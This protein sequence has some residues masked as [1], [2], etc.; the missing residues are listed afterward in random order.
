MILRKPYA[1][2][3]K[4][5]RFIHVI[6]SLLVIYSTYKTKI[7]LDFFNEYSNEIIN[8]TG[9]DL[10]TPLMPLFFQIIPLII[11]VVNLLLLFIMFIKKKPYLF[12][13]ISIGIFLFTFIILQISKST[14]NELYFSLIDIRTIRL[15]RD[16]ITLSFFTQLLSL[17]F[18]LIR[19]TGFD[20][21][22]FDFK[23]DMKQIEINEEDREEVEI[24]IKF[25]TNKK[26][27]NIRK[28]IRNFKY[29][30]KENKTLFIISCTLV[31][32]IFLSTITFKLVSVG[33]ILSQNDYFVGNNFTISVV[34]SYL[35]NDDYQ[36]KILSDEY[37]YLIIKLNIK[38]NTNKNIGLD[39]ATTKILIDNYLYTPITENRDS[40]FDF[41]FMYQGENIESDFQLKTLIYQ[42]PKQLADEKIIFYYVDKNNIDNDSNFKNTKVEIKYQNLIND[43]EE[44]EIK[45]SQQLIFE[46]SII[47]DYKISISG[48]DIKDEYKLNYNFCVTNE[49]YPS[50]EYITPT[51]ETNYDKSILKIKGTLENENKLSGIYDLYDFIE[52]FGSIKYTINDEVKYHSIK[53]KELKSKK[54]VENDIYYIEVL[55]E[56]E[57]ADNISLIFTIRNKK[58]EYILK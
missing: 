49:C 48:F 5:F 6:L 51:V 40:F 12:Y 4:H 34:D 46:N 24:Q 28:I 47:S 36:G 39:T 31:G 22:K 17:L 11:L 35:V 19:S 14:L 13:V 42:I 21:K 32:V 33:K 55:K 1:F 30:Y 2:F 57:Q 9:Q 10:V 26:I 18:T 27:R 8:I 16:L 41:G 29:A 38:N 15:I 53:L 23:S 43:D 50:V 37:Y 52:K 54:V 58:Y 3:I 25:D 45:A 44:Y 20:I 7:L 56:L